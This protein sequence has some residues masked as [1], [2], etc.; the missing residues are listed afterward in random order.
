MELSR[1]R[2]LQ[3]TAGVGAVATFPAF[4]SLA[5]AAQ[6]V[7]SGVWLAGDFH[8]HS[9]YSHDVWGGPGDDNTGYDELYTHGHTP[10]EQIALAELRGLDFLAITDHNRVASLYAP[11]Y[12]SDR[13]V[14]LPGYE[15]SL[16]HSDHSGVFMPSVDVLPDVIAADAGTAAWLDEI[17]ARGGM[18]VVNHPFYGNREDGDAMAW[19]HDVA[20][21]LR[22]DAVEVWNSMWLTRHD[23]VPAYEPDNHLAVQWWE[24]TFAPA[25]RA[26]AVGGS[27]NHWKLLDGMAGVGQPTTWVYAPEPTPAGLIAGVQ[28]GRTTIAWQPPALG[29][30][31]LLLDVVEQWS[32]R[33]AMVGG[34]VHG[35]GPVL[36]VV[37]VLGGAGQRLRL[38]SGGEVVHESVVSPLTPTVEVP[39]VLPEGG[40]LRAELLTDERYTLTALTSCVY[41]D[42]RAPMPVRR[43]PTR[44]RPVTYDGGIF[45]ASPAPAAAA[46][47]PT[48][49]CAH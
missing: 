22:F 39:L 1:R 28:A 2:F 14:L 31:Q 19:D 9:V 47:L 49:S 21:S 16:P 26:T 33:A 20:E 10:G 43:E 34:S 23:T 6:G 24:Q 3:L 44:G 25:R 37:T 42:G 4:R 7:P 35:D 32:G 40:W 30:P 15:H 38:V 8:C 41:A 5:N 36:A 13:L 11:D 27:D 12:V 48:C 29:G 45:A 18:A 17:H 46:G